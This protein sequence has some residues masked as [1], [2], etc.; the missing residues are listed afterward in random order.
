MNSR[1]SFSVTVHW[2]DEKFHRHDSLLGAIP[3]EVADHTAA[4]MASMVQEL[5]EECAIPKES[6]VGLVRDNASAM[7]SFGRLAQLDS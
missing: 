3:F 4:N 1:F 7:I 6:I 2:V 5:L